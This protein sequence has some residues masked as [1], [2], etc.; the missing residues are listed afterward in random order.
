MIGKQLN[1]GWRVVATGFCFFC[2]GVGGM[3]LSLFFF[4]LLVILP[5]RTDFRKC[6]AKQ[7]VHYTFRFFVGMMQFV[8][9]LNL[10]V[11]DADKLKESG[12]LIVANHPTLIDVVVLVSLLAEADCIVKHALWRNIFLRGVVSSTG[13]I[14]NSQPEQLISDCV[15][16]LKRGHTLI[17]FPEGTRTVPGRP[18][19]F[20]RGVAN[21]ALRANKVIRPV[22]IHCR[23]LTLSKGERWYNVPREG[24]VHITV[25]VG[26]PIQVQAFLQGMP[27]SIASRR[28]TGVLEN[29]FQQEVMAHE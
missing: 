6:L 7:I 21:I 19:R 20:Q 25:H 12:Q 10:K 29:Y 9:V 8:G 5:A 15:E 13:Y 28:L 4:P 22:I 23:P 17:T 16:C 3:L 11:V 26:D 27:V 14:S 24:R 2:F 1:Y 18:A